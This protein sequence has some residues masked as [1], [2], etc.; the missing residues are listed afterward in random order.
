[1]SRFEKNEKKC[2]IRTYKIASKIHHARAGN[3][4]LTWV[5]STPLHES[6]LPQHLGL[7]LSH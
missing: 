4:H 7:K 2:M 1:M 6:Q 3:I 5:G